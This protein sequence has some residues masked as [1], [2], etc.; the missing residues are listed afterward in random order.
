VWIPLYHNKDL[1]ILAR[2]LTLRPRADLLLR[3][4]EIG[5]AGGPGDP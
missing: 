1:T 3:Y 5:R 2:D 4:A